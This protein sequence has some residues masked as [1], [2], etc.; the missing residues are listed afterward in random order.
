MRRI[1]VLAACLLTTCLQLIAQNGVGKWSLVPHIGVSV[2]TMTKDYFPAEAVTWDV[3]TKWRSNVAGG[4]DVEYQSTSIVAV[5]VGLWYREGGTRY[6]D[7]TLSMDEESGTGSAFHDAYVRLNY[8]AIPVMA[9]ITVAKG[10][11]I[12]AGLEPSFLIDQKA[13]YQMQTYAY[14]TETKRWATSGNDKIADTDGSDYQKVLLSIPVGLSY[15][16]E[17]VLLDLRYDFGL[18]KVFKNDLSDSRTH[19]LLFTMGYRIGL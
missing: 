8:L 5:S 11:S 4:L 1:I 3:K 16:Y 19:G 15:E 7:L 12:N 13:Q 18:S 14:D 10:L 17:H 9:H 6:K 2:V